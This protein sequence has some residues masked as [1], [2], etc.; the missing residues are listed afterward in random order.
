[1]DDG[2][3][4]GSLAEILNLK[5]QD[6]RIKAM[7]FSRFVASTDPDE[8]RRAHEA[9]HTLVVDPL[10]FLSQVFQDTGNP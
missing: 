7:E 5:E 9:R 8:S 2:W 6:S 3:K 1:M 10:A 4:D